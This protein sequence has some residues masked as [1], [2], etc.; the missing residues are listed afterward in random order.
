MIEAPV[1]RRSI[2]ILIAS[3]ASALAIIVMLLVGSQALTQATLRQE[4]HDRMVAQQIEAQELRTQRMIYNVV[5]LQ[6]PTGH[7]TDY[8]GLYHSVKADETVWEAV[9]NA[10][11]QSGSP[12]DIS[13]GDF[14]PTAL[15]TIAKAKPSFLSMVAAFHRV[16]AAEAKDN[17]ASPE[18]V[19]PDVGL[20]YLA[21]P[22][23]LQSLVSV[24]SDLTLAADD[25]VSEIQKGEAVLFV[26]TVLVLT[27]EAL[28]IV[29]PA[30]GSLSAQMRL[31]AEK[32]VA[33]QTPKEQS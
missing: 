20:I 9:Q 32:I 5:L 27:V 21:E 29:R 11:Y 7:G 18:V 8:V 2:R 10:M 6:N 17:P 33:V 14:S 22:A 23:Y 3:Y 16:F 30:I 1:T 28:F 31:L 4:V 13:P 26:V 19:R 25:R 24:Y 15:S 12:I